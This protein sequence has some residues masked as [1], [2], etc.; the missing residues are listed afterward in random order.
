MNTRNNTRAPLLTRTSSYWLIRAALPMQEYREYSI[1]TLLLREESTDA[2]VR[3]EGEIKKRKERTQAK[4]VY[5]EKMKEE[6]GR[7]QKKQTTR[8][9]KNVCV[10]CGSGDECVFAV[11]RSQI[12]RFSFRKGRR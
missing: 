3:S 2:R 1:T 5:I 7:C 4:G 10:K 9:E 12:S 11:F 8:C 6:K